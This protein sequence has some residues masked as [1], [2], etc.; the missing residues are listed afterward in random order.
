MKTA[1]QMSEYYLQRKIEEEKRTQLLRR[2]KLCKLYKQLYKELRS[3]TIG[4][5]R[6]EIY[7]DP[8]IVER[9]KKKGYH[10]RYID[11]PMINRTN[12][13]QISVEEDT[14]DYGHT[15]DEVREY[16]RENKSFFSLIKAMF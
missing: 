16:I 5:I 4:M 11:F 7:I 8:E 2:K 3:S 1:K 13:L 6:P 15:M 10:I 9:F 14:H 12:V